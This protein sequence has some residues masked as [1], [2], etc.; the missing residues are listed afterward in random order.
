MY[1]IIASSIY[2]LLCTS[3]FILQKKKSSILFLKLTFIYIITFVS[4]KTESITIPIGII[5]GI[6]FLFLV[7]KDK[8]IV[9]FS[10]IF[11]ILTSTLLHFFIPPISIDHLAEST[12][13][14]EVVKKFNEV[15]YVK[16][17]LEKEEIQ[18]DIKKF[19]DSDLDIPYFMLVSYILIDNGVTVNGREELMSTP[20]ERHLSGTK[21]TTKDKAE[22]IYLN[23]NGIDYIGLFEYSK[24][25]PYLK[26]VVRG[27]VKQGLVD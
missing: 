9:L 6:I 2:F 13:V 18:L 3:V 10:L 25:E 4:F 11:G 27:S 7:K 5:L 19:V 26:V 14:Y 1:L 16:T 21:I 23:Y 15:E 8:K 20:H 12:E 17:F 24:K 22:E